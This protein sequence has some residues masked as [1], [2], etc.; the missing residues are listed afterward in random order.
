M[1]HSTLTRGLLVADTLLIHF[2]PNEPDAA[3]WSLV[4]SAGELTTMISK[5]TLSDASSIAAKHKTI[6]LLDNTSIHIESVQLPIK[7]RQKLLRAIPFAME[8]QIAD[9]VD[10]LH[11][12]A[13]KAQQDGSVPVAA[14]KKA[15]L[16][17]IIGDINDAG[18]EAT[19]IIPDTLC[20]TANSE[21][22]AVLLHKD[23][24]NLQ[25]NRFNG[26]EFDRDTLPIVITS[27]LEQE[28]PITPKKIILFTQD[29]E[30]ENTSVQ[31]ITDVLPENIELINVSYNTTPLVIYC[32]QYQNAM[33]LNLLQG[34]YKPKRKNNIEWQRWRLAAALTVIWL[35]LGLGSAGSEYYDLQD[36]NKQLRIQIEK[37]YKTA[38]PKSKKIVNARV[39]ME[40]KLKELK[41]GSSSSKS[42]SMLALLSTSASALSSEKGITLQSINYRN[43]KMDLELTGTNLQAIESL[44][45]KINRQPIQ[46]E[47]ISSSSEKDQVKGNIRIQR[48]GS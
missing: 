7:N 3:S 19:A 1:G 5:G 16:E 17:T 31:D 43:N 36:K 28:T 14:I 37:I 39:Q 26:C 29:G 9:E 45:K 4:N 11:F 25:L 44:N 38:F 12:V 15:T 10:D 34:K 18:I 23:H 27:L 42:T 40:Q 24:A 2:N 22:W 8:E 6:V 46:S 33:S 13:G 41:G 30:T 35:G 48:A 47:I 20:L 32:G 21:Q